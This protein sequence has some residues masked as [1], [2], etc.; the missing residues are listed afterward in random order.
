MDAQ[1][2]IA[3]LLATFAPCFTR[4]GFRYFLQFTLARMGLMGL[5]HCVTEVMRLT[6]LHH[7]VHWTTPYLFMKVASWS[8][9]EVSQRLL[10][11]VATTIGS[12]EVLIVA[13]DDTVVKKW[14]RKFFGLGR[15]VDP[16]DKN[17]GGHKRRVLGHCWVVMAVLWERGTNSWFAFPVACRLFV[18]VSVCAEGAFRTKIEL[19]VTLLRHMRWPARQVILVGDNLYARTGLATGLLLDGALGPVDHTM[20]ISRLRCNAALYER[21]GKRRPG[22]RGAPRKRGRKTDA[23]AL[24]ERRDKRRQLA[25]NIY[26][27]RVVL[28]AFVDVLI[29]S[30]TLGSAPILVIIFPQ[31]GGKKMNVFFSTDVTMDPVRVMEIYSARFKIEDVFDEIKTVG[32][33]GDCRQRGAIALDRHATLS[34]VAYT[35]LRLL[36]VTHSE[37]QDL[38]A[39]PWWHPKGAPSV[40]RLRRAVFKALQLSPSLLPGHKQANNSPL[41]APA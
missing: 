19:A 40:T 22:K 9:L 21:P 35:L 4:P 39:E 7:L 28:D 20:L 33:F 37:L 24:Y 17:P 12:P 6:G 16:T 18:P 5:P 2:L 34:L 23:K 32:G 27:K 30:R 41:E 29:P 11:L 36:S 8:C 26:G 1:A 10:N 14:G 13:I 38:E 25:V 3:P 31:R 15:Y